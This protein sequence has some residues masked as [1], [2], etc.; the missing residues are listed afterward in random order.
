MH[1]NATCRPLL[2]PWV[3]LPS[4]YRHSSC[5]EFLSHFCFHLTFPRIRLECTV[6]ITFIYKTKV[7]IIMTMSL[8]SVFSA[9]IQMRCPLLRDLMQFFLKASLKINRDTPNLDIVLHG[10]YRPFTRKCRDLSF[11]GRPLSFSGILHHHNCQR[12]FDIFQ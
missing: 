12:K 9:S 4:T 8:C 1:R 6:V 5:F 11:I 7:C 3:S 10:T 2:K